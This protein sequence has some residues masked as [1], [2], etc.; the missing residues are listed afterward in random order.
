VKVFSDDIQ[1]IKV[2][3]QWR[4][5]KKK[6]HVFYRHHNQAWH[7]QWPKWVIPSEDGKW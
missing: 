2:F 4:E 6:K 7:N 3:L 1:G 5:S